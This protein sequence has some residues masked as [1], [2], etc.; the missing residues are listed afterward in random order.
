MTLCSTRGDL[1]SQPNQI[2]LAAVMPANLQEL[3]YDGRV[4]NVTV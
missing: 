1:Q 3:S 4:D 2:W